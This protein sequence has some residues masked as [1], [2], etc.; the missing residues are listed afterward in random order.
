MP[1]HA[2]SMLDL[3]S[4]TSY[5]SHQTS[6]SRHSLALVQH[7]PNNSLTPKSSFRRRPP[8]VASYHH[9]FTGHQTGQPKVKYSQYFFGAVPSKSESTLSVPLH[10]SSNHC[11]SPT[12]NNHPLNDIKETE[13]EK[14][15]MMMTKLS[16][17]PSDTDH[18]NVPTNRHILQ[19]QISEPAKV[20]KSPAAIGSKSS[21][22]IKEL[23]NGLAARS[24]FKRR[25]IRKCGSDASTF[26][27]KH[28]LK[29][30]QIAQNQLSNILYSNFYNKKI[31]PVFGSQITLLGDTNDTKER[32]KDT[33]AVMTP[34]LSH[35]QAK[36]LSYD[37][38]PKPSAQ[39]ASPHVYL[40][41][42]GQLDVNNR[43]NSCQQLSM[44]KAD[45]G[46]YHNHLL[47]KQ[48]MALMG[49]DNKAHNSPRILSPLDKS[50]MMLLIFISTL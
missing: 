48:N 29:R 10:M 23:F 46:H 14:C 31:G 33:S 37:F 19:K 42:V 15:N 5:Q 7:L 45:T 3:S 43:S 1:I 40:P 20:E 39:F 50:G 25:S 41:N 26:Y 38:S 18:V 12:T 34:L 4:R 13:N 30:S 35:L 47:L 2:T 22:K 17:Q 36:H 11:H 27:G 32:K 8:S 6:R 44:L 16:K 21:Q 49:T 9:L 28:N 24:S